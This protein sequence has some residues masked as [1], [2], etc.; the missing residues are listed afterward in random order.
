MAGDRRCRD[1]DPNGD[2]LARLNAAAQAPQALEP[3]LSGMDAARKRIHGK[4]RSPFL[5]KSRR[6][7]PLPE[8]D[9]RGLTVPSAR[10][11]RVDGEGRSGVCAGSGPIPVERWE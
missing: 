10:F 2:C 6:P 8:N 9:R 1:A 3:G 11:S 4:T 5:G 7:L